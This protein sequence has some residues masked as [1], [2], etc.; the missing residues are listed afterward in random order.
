MLQTK[1]KKVIDANRLYFD[2]LWLS[3]SA[4]PRLSQ[5]LKRTDDFVRRRNG[6][7]HDSGSITDHLARRHDRIY[8]N[9]K[10]PRKAGSRNHTRNYRPEIPA[11]NGSHPLGFSGLET[12]LNSVP[13]DSVRPF[14]NEDKLYIRISEGFFKG[15]YRIGGV[16][17]SL[18]MN[19][20]SLKKDTSLSA[21]SLIAKALSSY[22]KCDRHFSYK[23]GKFYAEFSDGN[24]QVIVQLKV[25]GE[26]AYANPTTL[27]PLQNS[28]IQAMFDYLENQEVAPKYARLHSNEESQSRPKIPFREIESIRYRSH[29]RKR[30]KYMV[31]DKVVDVSDNYPPLQLHPKRFRSK[32]QTTWAYSPIIRL[33]KRSSH[34]S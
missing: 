28:A 3:T 29:K 34:Y 33:P 24:E 9:R 4:D 7:V 26:P 32:G 1:S 10:T 11:L 13:N 21:H 14:L 16:I 20:T 6:S 2:I 19:S 5:L 18:V 22:P 8:R 31:V 23:N 25:K 30:A 12:V 17:D 15:V 27:Q